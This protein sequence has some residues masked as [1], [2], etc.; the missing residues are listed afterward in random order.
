MKSRYTI[1]HHDHGII[2]SAPISIDDYCAVVTALAELY[3][4]DLCDGLL[5]ARYH[6]SVCLTTK[7]KSELW[8]KE[9]GLNEK[10]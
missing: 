1:T 7:E 3:D 8:R 9:L 4:Y 10:E 6:A 2:I 5:A